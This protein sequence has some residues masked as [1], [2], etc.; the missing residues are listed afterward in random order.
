M[1]PRALVSQRT[2]RQ[3]R[4]WRNSVVQV[5]GLLGGPMGPSGNGGGVQRPQKL[6]IPGEQGPRQ[7]GPKLVLPGKRGPPSGGNPP[8]PSNAGPIPQAPAQ[9][10]GYSNFRPPPGFMDD[11]GEADGALESLSTQEMLDRLQQTRGYWH[12]LATYLPKLQREGIDGSIVEE[13][14]GVDRRTQNM[15][16]NSSIVYKSLKKSGEMS[17]QS[18]AYFDQEGGERLL[19]ELRFLS[20]EQR[21]AA[22]IYIVE[23]QMDDRESTLLA[24]SVK[25]HERRKG[26]NEGF[27]GSP[28]D[29]MAYKHYRDALENKRGDQVAE[30]IKRGLAV[31][32][33]NGAREA[34][35]ELAASVELE[36]ENKASGIDEV[37]LI[38]VRLLKEETGYK[39]I[40]VVG[41]LATLDPA[42]VAGAPKAATQGV[43]SKFALPTEA[44][45]HS[46]DWVPIPSW[47]ATAT[48]SRP[49]AIEVTNCAKL[50]AMRVTSGVSNDRDAIKIQ[51]EGLVVADIDTVFDDA[52]S[53]YVAQDAEGSFDLLTLDAIPNP[54]T[55]VGKVILLCRPPARQ[56]AESF[57]ANDM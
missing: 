23:Q 44:S 54:S 52:T 31:A 57:D 53:Y 6:V 49:V 33:S 40:P 13:M 16:V 21:V 37:K 46:Y 24:K 25:E 39:P 11:G 36:V 47:S 30:Y 1:A 35:E 22:A 38:S 55:I 10:G 4:P 50:H 32:E 5:S 19:H 51:G 48:A 3:P 12:E 20:V 41:N 43:F 29:C 9:P 45:S 14:S 27:T 34:L 7:G 18:L 8:S 2:V 26:E 42:V 56:T 28:A 15:W 17:E